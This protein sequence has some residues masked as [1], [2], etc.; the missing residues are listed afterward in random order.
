M[1]M[2]RIEMLNR[3]KN[4]EPRTLGVMAVCL[5]PFALCGVLSALFV[6][7]GICARCAHFMASGF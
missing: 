1:E 2:T 4:L 3:L 6:C 7:I 5:A